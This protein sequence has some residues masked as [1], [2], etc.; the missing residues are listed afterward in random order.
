MKTHGGKRTGAGRPTEYPVSECIAIAKMV[1]RHQ[2]IHGGTIAKALRTLEEE[3]QLPAGSGKALLRYLTP[4]YLPAGI[5][6]VLNTHEHKG[7]HEGI[8]LGIASLYSSPKK[9]IK[10]ST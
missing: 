7:K 8:H 4:Q 5:S 6:R 2:E 3:G 10:K 9:R 1:I